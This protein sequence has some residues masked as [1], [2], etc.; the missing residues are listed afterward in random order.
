MMIGVETNT[1]FH[2]PEKKATPEIRTGV[3]SVLGYDGE[4]QRAIEA[5]E[6]IRRHGQC[7]C[8]DPQRPTNSLGGGPIAAIPA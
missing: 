4:R 6:H 1:G 5:A 2:Q 3:H 7:S 8:D